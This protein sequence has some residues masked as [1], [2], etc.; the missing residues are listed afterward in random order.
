MQRPIENSIEQLEEILIECRS[1]RILLITGR[2]SYD[3]SVKRS[4]IEVI[5]SDYSVLRHCDFSVNPNIIDIVKGVKIAKGFAPDTIIG[6]GGGSVM[7]TAKIIATFFSSENDIYST[8]TQNRDIPMR[9]NKLIL[10]PTTA[11]SGSEAT[12]FAVIYDGNDKFS[13]ASENILPEYVI[14]DPELTHTVPEKL[15]AITAFD[16]F[17]QSIESYWSVGATNESIDYATE[18]IMIIKKIFSK[19]FDNPP[20]VIRE[21]MMKASFLSGKAINITKTTGPHA[22]SYALTKSFN[23]PHGLAVM[24]TMPSFFRFNTDTKDKE[25][26]AKVSIEEYSMRV[27]KLFDLLNVND[28]DQAVDSILEMISYVGFKNKL[29]YYG[30]NDNE[31]LISLSKSVNMERLG[32]NPLLLTPKNIL[33]ILKESY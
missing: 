12:H 20:Y 33:S 22:I 28:S 16:A 10:V 2:D 11:G 30:I 32:N 31:D 8:I 26:H 27:S 9:H 3:N 6:I 1:K 4:K 29:R 5:L 25:L 21:K 13:V 7:D 15:T 24:L 23:I 17:C 19:L 14:L 18:S